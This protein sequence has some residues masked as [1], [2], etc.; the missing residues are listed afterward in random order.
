M[1][2]EE[3]VQIDFKEAGK[4]LMASSAMMFVLSV[5]GFYTMVDVETE[6]QDASQT[7]EDGMTHLES[8]ESQRTI[9]AIEDMGRIAS[10]AQSL[11]EG[12]EQAEQSLN[13]TEKAEQEVTQTKETYQWLSLIA[14]MLFVA[15]ILLYLN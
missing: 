2:Q 9:E 6:I 4:I 15:G 14:I 10:E 12:F 7:L 11:E 1:L 8:E 5:F 3:G 13:N